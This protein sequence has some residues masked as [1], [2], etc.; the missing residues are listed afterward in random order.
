MPGYE[1][2]PVCRI[3]HSDKASVTIDLRED[4][5][6][7]DGPLRVIGPNYAI[8]RTDRE[9]VNRSLRPMFH[10]YR[11]SFELDF[12]VGDDM[13]DHDLL[14]RIVSAFMDA[15]YVVSMSLDGGVTFRRVTLSRYDGPDPIAGKTFAGATFR[16][17]FR[18]ADLID[19]IP[20]VA[21]GQ[22]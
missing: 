13:G 15:R 16:L 1:W 22:W 14:A 21:S 5:Q 6:F 10:G 18:C 12:A 17:G 7:V 9:D 8:V 20:S 3:D 11:V 2:W 4:M 19:E